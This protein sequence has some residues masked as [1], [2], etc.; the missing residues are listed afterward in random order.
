MTA[1]A[2]DMSGLDPWVP[3]PTPF[4]ELSLPPFRATAPTFGQTNQGSMSGPWSA[5]EVEA[6]MQ[7][8]RTGELRSRDLRTPQA[9][10]SRYLSPGSG[11]L[12]TWW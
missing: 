7:Q 5:A 11:Y 10:G 4:G 8:Q 2:E 6:E 9:P 1:G 3:P 12:S